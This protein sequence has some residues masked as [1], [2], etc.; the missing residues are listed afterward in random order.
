MPI[1]SKAAGWS[2][3]NLFTIMF[4][5]RMRDLKSGREIWAELILGALSNSDEQ[6]MRRTNWYPN[7][8]CAF[9]FEF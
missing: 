4:L 7:V 3:S 8:Q 1:Y 5:V 9:I 6:F 2:D